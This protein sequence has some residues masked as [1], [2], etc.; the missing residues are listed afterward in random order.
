M[1]DSYNY[2][3]YKEAM[4][5]SDFWNINNPG[6]W[7]HGE[8]FS[9]LI[10]KVDGT[11]GRGPIPEPKSYGIHFEKFEQGNNPAATKQGS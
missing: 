5:N 10:S 9:F 1:L 4:Q 11:L 6:L 3:G 7:A 2:Y 8:P